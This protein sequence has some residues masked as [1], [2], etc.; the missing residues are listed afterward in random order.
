MKSDA[1]LLQE[2]KKGNLEAFDQLVLRHQKTIYFL[3]LRLVG[4]ETDAE[5]LAQKTFVQV[6]KNGHRFKE[7]SQFKTWI[8]RI[9]VNLG[10]NHLRSRSRKNEIGLEEVV[11]SSPST[12]LKSL[13]SKEETREVAGLLNKLPEKQRFT[14]ILRIYQELSYAEISQ[15][16]GCSLGTAKA[17]FHQA[18]KKLR[19]AIRP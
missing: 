7:N 18:I 8:F 19:S 12:P 1:E 9:A 6:F 5:D 10:K 2:F 16:M 13:V 4:D 3:V 15:V 14:V 11:L 17:N